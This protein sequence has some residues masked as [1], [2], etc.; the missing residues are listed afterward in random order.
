[1]A[2]YLGKK[3]YSILPG[4][5]VNYT[6]DIVNQVLSRRR[7]HL[8][9]RNDF[10]QMMVDREEEGEPEQEINQQTDK[11]QQW[12]TLKKSIDKIISCLNLLFDCSF[13]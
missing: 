9:R 5:A 3:G 7:Q 8:E 2:N 10:I 13:E 12:E 1:M 4:D 11:Q 6:T